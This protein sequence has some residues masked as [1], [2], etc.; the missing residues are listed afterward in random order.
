MD[1]E[2]EA[3]FKDINKDDIRSRLKQAGAVL[4]KPEFLQKRVAFHMPKGNEVEGGWARVR[5]EGDKITISVKIIDGN[6]I[7]DQKEVCVTVDN[8][9]KAIS[10][11]ESLGCRQKAYIETRREL[12]KLDDVEITIDEWPF[13]EPFVEVEGS[14]EEEVKL[15]SEKIGFDWK[16]AMFCGVVTLYT[17]KYGVS[18]DLV[19]NLTPRITFDIDNPFLLAK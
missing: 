2:F 5:D 19:N 12:W 7:T 15:V 1:I 9:N 18:T 4:L 8:F 10:L 17:A 11:L 13:L 6:K 14:S 3:T 16:D